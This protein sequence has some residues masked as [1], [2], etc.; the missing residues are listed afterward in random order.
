MSFFTTFRQFLVF[1]Y[2]SL[3]PQI[4]RIIFNIALYIFQKQEDY[5]STFSCLEVNIAS[6]GW[7]NAL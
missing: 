2:V 1:P 7:V 5:G 3:L 6:E 4:E